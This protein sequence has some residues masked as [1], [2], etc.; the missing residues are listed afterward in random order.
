M[1]VI[2]MTNGETVDLDTRDG[3]YNYFVRYLIEHN[4]PELLFSVLEKIYVSGSDE[5]KEESEKSIDVKGNILNTIIDVA[6]I[7][8]SF[9]QVEIYLSFNYG[10]TCQQF[11]FV[12]SSVQGVFLIHF[13][14][15]LMK[16]T[17]SNSWNDIEGSHV[18]VRQCV[19]KV[20]S[21]GHILRNDL[22]I[23]PEQEYRNET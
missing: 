18:R 17:D 22:W 19:N 21:I 16:I 3:A 8:K 20:L 7:K 13:M 6:D 4:A 14:N 23:T 10:L 1:K 12:F 15:R 9:G 11:S 5:D 2:E